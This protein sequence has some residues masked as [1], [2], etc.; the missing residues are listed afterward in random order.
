M[1]ESAKWRS[2]RAAERTGSMRPSGREG[3]NA[4]AFGHHEGVA[5]EDDGY[6]VVPAA[7]TAALEVI[8][9]EFPLEVLIGAL[10]TPAL[11]GDA[12]ELVEGRVRGQRREEVVGGLGLA[13]APLDQQ[14]DRRALVEFVTL[15]GAAWRSEQR[16]RR[17]FR[18]AR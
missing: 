17:T 13:V 7:E 11:H 12:D 16:V 10:G 18:C 4:V 15:L 5:A 2:G 9:T 1:K 8:E 3:K 14:P 6:V